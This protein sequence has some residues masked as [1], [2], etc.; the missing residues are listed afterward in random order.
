MS[1]CFWSF[2]D[3]NA[4]TKNR[5]T[6]SLL[7]GLTSKWEGREMRD[8]GEVD[9]KAS[10]EQEARAYSSK[11]SPTKRVPCFTSREASFQPCILWSGR[12][13]FSYQTSMQ[14][15]TAGNFAQDKFITGGGGRH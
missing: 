3:E 9:T 4:I 14:E 7:T 6:Q 13:F 12:H 11:S 8:E 15:T 1:L 5:R 2:S 10:S